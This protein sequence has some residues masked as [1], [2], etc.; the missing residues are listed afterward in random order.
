MERTVVKASRSDG[1]RSRQTIL[2]AA[3][4]LATLEG[5]D[6]LS[7]GRL[8]EHIGMSKSGLYAHFRS[9]EDLQIATIETAVEI[10]NA[11][12]VAPAIG[13]ADPLDHLVSLGDLFL[14]HLDREVFPGG[15]FFAAVAAEFDTHSGPVHDRIAAAQGEWMRLLT[16]LVEAAKQQGEISPAEDTQQ[17]VFEID[18]YL[19][20]ANMAFLMYQDA[21]ALQRAARALRTRLG[22]PPEYVSSITASRPLSAPAAAIET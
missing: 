17:L 22:L 16:G 20:M 10:Y 4:R 7:I 6:G 8:A 18:A 21:I 15:C 2:D 1:L 12:V 14:S 11:E 19:L 3:A 9:K 13:V 5:L